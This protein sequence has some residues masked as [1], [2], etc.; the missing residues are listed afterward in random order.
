M[1][2]VNEAEYVWAQMLESLL[3]KILKGLRDKWGRNGNKEKET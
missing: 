1:S 2:K 3:G